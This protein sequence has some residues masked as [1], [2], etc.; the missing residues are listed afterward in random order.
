MKSMMKFKNVETGITELTT[1]NYNSPIAPIVIVWKKN[2]TSSRFFFWLH[3]VELRNKFYTE[4]MSSD[5]DISQ[6]FIETSFSKLE[7]WAKV[8]GMYQL[9]RVHANLQPSWLPKEVFILE[10][11][12]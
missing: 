6:N 7:F 9:N 3:E 11:A 5:E 12:I 10:N 1:S 4:P 2:N 8:T